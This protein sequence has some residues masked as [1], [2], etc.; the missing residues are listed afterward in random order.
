[1]G[2]GERLG[3]GLGIVMPVP[4]N[5]QAGVHPGATQ[6]Q[7]AAPLPPRR[8]RRQGGGQL[9]QQRCRQGLAHAALPELRLIRQADPVGREHPRQRVQQH[10][11]HRQRL[12]HGAGVLAAGAAEAAQHRPAHVVPLLDRDPA[13][14][15]RHPLHGDRQGALGRLFGRIGPA[16]AEGHRQRLK[17]RPRWLWIQGLITAWA[18]HGRHM[19]RLQA[20]QQQVGVGDAE[21][22]AAAVAGRAGIGAGGGGPHLQPQAIEADQRTAASGHGV[23]VEHGRL[24]RQAIELGLLTPLPGRTAAGP[25]APAHIGGGAAHVEA[26][27]RQ[28]AEGRTDAAGPH[29][30]TGRAGE[31]RVL[32]AQLLRGDQAAARLHHPQRHV[33]AEGVL[34]LAEVIA[35][36]RRHARLQHRGVG[37]RQPARQRTHLMGEGD[38]I[39]AEGLQPAT[40]GLLM[41]RMPGGVEQRH[42]HAGDALGA[43]LAQLIG[44][45]LIAQQRLQFAAVSRQ[46]PM[47]LQH[48][49][50]QRSRPLD[51]QGEQIRTVLI[52]D[53]EQIGKA[54][55][56]QQQRRPAAV[57]QHRIGGHGGAEPHLCDQAIRNRLGSRRIQAEQ[58]AD[59]PHHRITGQPRLHRQHLAH[60]QPPSG[61][62][63]HQIGE[64]AAPIHPEAPAGLPHPV[65]RL[66]RLGRT[67]ETAALRHHAPLAS[68]SKPM[69]D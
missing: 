68:S 27:Q 43:G 38:V 12:G 34:N 54:A 35:Q 52:T 33:R 41:A 18:E 53:R 49:P 21:G 28:A 55:V 11:P 29:Q 22:P 39:E 64:G 9:L 23:D 30:A 20:A 59:R 7:R 40:E 19:G 3:Q 13:D 14:R 16:A 50:R 24:Q 1:M 51:R 4:G 56:D 8:C 25:L 69:V 63:G 15:L 31:D 57:L 47:H 17:C 46:A 32:G 48:P 10:A 37:P 66:H 60:L 5:R 62:A 65:P 44:Q 36:H 2:I 42:G 61:V 67:L 58:A 26:H 45:G 6:L